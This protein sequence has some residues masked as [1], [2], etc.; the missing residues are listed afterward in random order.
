M[1]V[2]Q[3]VRR[4]LL[5]HKSSSTAYVRWLRKH[6]AE[7][8]DNVHFFNPASSRIDPVRMDWISIGSNCKFTGPLTVLAHDYSFSVLIDSHQQIWQSGGDYVS[9]GEN[10]FTGVQ[11]TILPGVTIGDNV[12]IGAGSIVTRDIPPNCVVAGNPARII[13]SLDEYRRKREAR[14]VSDALRHFA[15][16]KARQQD[17]PDT[18]QMQEYAL[19]Y[20]ERSAENWARYM[21]R[22]TFPGCAPEAVQRAF[23]QS[24]PLMT[25]EQFLRQACTSC[26]TIPGQGVAPSS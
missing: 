7:I 23:Y 4:L 26:D 24:S 25:E 12:I 19:L 5:G 10:V 6:G 20:L 2:R 11:V 17:I 9:I 15:H 16:L 18:I 3:I 8:G 22:I 1:S 14:F 13:M 21:S